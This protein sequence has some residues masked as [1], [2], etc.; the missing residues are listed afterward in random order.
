MKSCAH[1]GAES[2]AYG[3]MQAGRHHGT[4]FALRISLRCPN[5]MP[6]YRGER[7]SVASDTPF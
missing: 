4:M 6:G 1:L 3:W 5:D 7:L 2:S